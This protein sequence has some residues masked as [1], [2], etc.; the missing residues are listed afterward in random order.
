[1]NKTGTIC[2]CFAARL[3]AMEIGGLQRRARLAE[4]GSSMLITT[5]LI[6]AIRTAKW[7]ST[8]DATNSDLS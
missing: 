4:N 5:C 6:I 2:L 7:S 8:K 1:M 3:F